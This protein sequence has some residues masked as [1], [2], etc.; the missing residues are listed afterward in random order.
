MIDHLNKQQQQAVK[1]V[2]NPVLVLA[3]AGSGKTSVITQKIAW[4]IMQCNYQPYHIAAVTF[5]N[6]AAREMRSRVDALLPSVNTRGLIVS[7]F[8]TLGLR[9]LRQE[10]KRFNLKP[11]FSIVD[12]DDSAH[13]L[14]GLL[15]EDDDGDSADFIKQL[16]S[17]ISRWKNDGRFPQELMETAEN[18]A[19]LR[20]ANLYD[21]YVSTLRSYNSVD[22]DDLILMPLQLFRDNLEVL[23]SW[24]QKIRYLLVD[25]YQDTNLAQYQ[26]VNLL[27]ANNHSL[28]VVGDDDQ[29]IYAWR[30]A[31]PDNLLQLQ[32]DYPDLEIIKLEQN[33]RSTNRILTAAN[34][35]IANNPRQIEKQ[36]WSQ[37]GVGE[38]I[39][40]QLRANE[41]DEI[42][43]LVEE[44]RFRMATTNRQFRDFA[45]LYR[46]NYQARQLELALQAGAIPYHMSGGT[47]FYSRTEIKDILAYLRLLINPDDDNALLRI[48]NTPRRQIG[49]KT[50]MQWSEYA[51][52]AEIPLL[53]ACEHG[54]LHEM[55][56]KAQ[57]QKLLGFKIWIEQ[58]QR[59]CINNSPMAAVREMLE[60]IN[61]QEWVYQNTSDAKGAE[62]RL[63]NVALLLESIERIMQY[64]EDGDDNDDDI[65]DIDDVDDAFSNAVRRLLL[66]DILDQQEQENQ[67]NCV[68]LMTLHA[69]KG[70]EF[71]EVFLIGV[72]E[73]LLPH[74]NSIDTD[75]VEEERRLFYVGITRA[76]E[77]LRI[78]LCKQRRAFGE[79][80]SITASR[81]I[82]ELPDDVERSGFHES[83]EDAQ[84]K[85][86]DAF[87]SFAKMFEV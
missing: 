58:V 50:V 32:D 84:Q 57:I 12:A 76:R 72:E 51:K 27:S 69:C 1:S 52:Q 34:H 2:Q 36:L 24:Q 39:R 42:D 74:R 23:R 62:K 54:Q 73:N 48:I 47:S 79:N 6:K 86:D 61:Y 8:H 85:A 11:G 29:S 63:S 4:L 82:D 10:L 33:Y 16:Q 87:D 66:Q 60:D 70:L 53:Q 67:D 22:F 80:Q 30:G 15:L 18:A 21:R 40:I 25:E 68:Q 7:T 56:G 13:I 17:Y 37:L 59:N 49:S 19:E 43:W 75:N 35:V 3:G 71:P 65:A 83:A 81:F 38:P 28:T 31:Q 55:L 26:L 9:I 77:N 14:K 20:L 44:I 41:T 5:T 45:V 64:N 46:S 78:S